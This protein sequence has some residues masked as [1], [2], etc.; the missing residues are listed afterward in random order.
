MDK[1]IKQFK[2]GERVIAQKFIQDM[3]AHLRQR[4]GTV[5]GYGFIPNFLPEP[6]E[7]YSVV[8]MWDDGEKMYMRESSLKSL[9]RESKNFS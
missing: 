4:T 6:D 9:D 8:V 5:L 7:K 1:H 2:A 3:Y